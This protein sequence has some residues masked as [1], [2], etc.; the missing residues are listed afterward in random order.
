M[1][2]FPS[3]C[4]IPLTNHECYGHPSKPWRDFFF[5][6][7]TIKTHKKCF[8]FNFL[9]FS[10]IKNLSSSS[11]TCIFLITEIFF[12]QI[13]SILLVFPSNK[14]NKIGHTPIYFQK[15][16]EWLLHGRNDKWILSSIATRLLPF[17]LSH[18]SALAFLLVNVQTLTCITLKNAIICCW[19]STIFKVFSKYFFSSKTPSSSIPPNFEKNCINPRVDSH[20][21]FWLLLLSKLIN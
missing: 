19:C 3:T 14:S 11:F 5:S 13:F 4:L 15:M 17:W 8:R 2:W 6:S 1:V 7:H 16:T 21:F 10:P 20:H 18:P 12:Y 9:H